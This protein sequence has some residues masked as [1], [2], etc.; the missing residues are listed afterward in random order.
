MILFNTKTRKKQEFGT[1][2]KSKT[3]RMYTCGP[4]V[5]FTAH[6]GNLRAYIC[7]DILKKSLEISGFN[8]FDVMNLTD[9]GHLTSD[10]DDGEDKM[11]KSARL[12]KLRPEQIAQKYTEEFF[13]DCG[14]L[15]IRKP[16]VIALATKYVPQI[17]EFIKGLEKKGFTYKTSD[18]IYFDSSKFPRYAVL[19][20][21]NIEGNKAGAR[22]DIGEKRNSHDFCLWKFCQ[23]EV[24]QKW[25]SP[26]GVGCPGWHIECSAISLEHLGE[27]FDI[28]TGGVDH[29]PIH[30]TNEIAQTESLTG[31]EMCRFWF[32]NEFMMV[33]NGKMSKSLG[34]V[35][36]LADL[37]TKGYGP[38]D[39]RYYILL[40]NYRTIMNFTFEGMDS[41]KTA[42]KNLREAIAKHKYGSADVRCNGY[43]TDFTFAIQDDLNTPR[44][45]AVLW[46]AVKNEPASKQVY[47]MALEMDKILSLDLDC[48]TVTEQAPDEI[49]EFAQKRLAAKQAR[50][51]K[52]ADELRQK[53]SKA[54][55]E[56][57][58][59]KEGYK[60]AKK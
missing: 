2:D 33:D 39:F 10:A 14:L 43:M 17:I 49:K 6:I 37:K 19:S 9:V 54:G 11:E 27:T 51:F 4:T 38:L 56:I 15:N 13:R 18:G 41:A 50:D 35:Y 57:L 25:N 28:H 16:K 12:Q 29:I 32:H 21:A 8:V 26:W 47:E 59:T 44:A 1:A 20:G 45:L 46:Y 24:I 58:D 55:W 7:A 53:I 31:N 42:L 52:T 60:L 22:V 30:H 48:E 3:V 40:A 23:P 36:T 34:N 5:Y